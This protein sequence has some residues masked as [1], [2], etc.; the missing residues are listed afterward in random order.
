[1]SEPDPTPDQAGFLERLEGMCD[2]IAQSVEINLHFGRGATSL[3]ASGV[4]GA[5]FLGLFDFW[6]MLFLPQDDRRPLIVFALL[7]M[8]RYL[9]HGFLK[10]HQVERLPAPGYTGRPLISLILPIDEVIIK[11]LEPWIV[12]VSG[13]GVFLSFNRPLGLYLV[14][15]GIMLLSYVL[16]IRSGKNPWLTLRRSDSPKID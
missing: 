2:S 10:S 7:T 16:R 8:A 11:L 4:F 9:A 1:M 3:F 13:L 12:M 15:G 5:A 14:L 6:M